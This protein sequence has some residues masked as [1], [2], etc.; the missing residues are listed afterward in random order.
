MSQVTAGTNNSF[1]SR[2]NVAQ[3]L[4]AFAATARH[5]EGQSGIEVENSDGP[6]VY[7]YTLRTKIADSD[8]EDYAEEGDAI[9]SAGPDVGEEEDQY[10]HTGGGGRIIFGWTSRWGIYIR[11]VQ[12]ETVQT[13]KVTADEV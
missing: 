3:L 4:K 6:A 12:R 7:D 8:K 13:K 2:L 9:C 10:K 5:R 11:S 1:E